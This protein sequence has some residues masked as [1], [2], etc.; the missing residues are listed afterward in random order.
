MFEK[1]VL[2]LHAVVDSQVFLLLTHTPTLKLSNTPPRNSSDSGWLE[3]VGL[4]FILIAI[5]FAAYY[6]SKLVGRFTLGQLK[7]SNFHVIDSY[8]ISPNKFLQ[9]VKI[10]NKYIVISVSKDNVQFITELDET[11]VFIREANIKENMSFK[12]IFEKI[13]NRAE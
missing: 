5:L 10:A 9:I 12:Q 4:V 2:Q 8:R 7:N 1:A 11:E 13:K 3:M 6:T